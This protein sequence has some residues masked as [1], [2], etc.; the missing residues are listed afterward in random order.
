VR[1]SEA[2]LAAVA[3]AAVLA[4]G[5]NG[6]P[7]RPKPG[8]I[9]VR[10]DRVSDFKALY[11]DN[12]TACHGVDGKGGAGAIGLANPV[13]LA[14]ADDATIRA[15]TANGVRGTMMPAFVQSAGGMLTDQQV[16]ILV[17]GIRSWARADALA[18][19]EAPP[20][21]GGG[22]DAARGS[23]VYATFCASCHGAG[24]TGG[25]KAG[26]IV[27]GSFLGLVSDQGLRTTI[28]AGRPDIGQ[29]DWKSDVSGRALTAEDVSDVVA[30][31]AAQRPATPGQPYPGGTHE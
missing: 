6:L 25:P 14:I 17:K 13:Y 27:D 30:W 5:C 24:G 2:R 11:S 3:L 31:L 29:P 21:A 16:E 8:S 23:T 22:G 26:S 28:I 7:G 1:R 20:Y 19:A 15:A 4:D 9:E 10:P 12:C 18:G